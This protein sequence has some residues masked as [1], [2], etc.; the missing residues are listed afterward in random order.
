MDGVRPTTVDSNTDAAMA[1]AITTTKTVST[2]P[3]WTIATVL[4]WMAR[5][6]SM[7]GETR[8]EG[9]VPPL[10]PTGVAGKGQ[11]AHPT[12]WMRRMAEYRGLRPAEKTLYW[13]S[14]HLERFANFCRKAGREASEI[15]EV[16]AKEFLR[17]ISAG[18]GGGDPE[19]AG[20][21]ERAD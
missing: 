6:A 19:P 4:Q 13:W 3:R 1:A 14:V 16:A 12:A 17:M 7:A 9:C 18:G 20:L 10:P 2:P 5:T 11:A 15:P 21:S 8:A